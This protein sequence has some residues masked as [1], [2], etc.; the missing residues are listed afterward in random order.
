M[1]EETKGSSVIWGWDLWDSRKASMSENRRDL[2]RRRT[3]N[4]WMWRV[5]AG[6]AEAEPSL[7]AVKE[8]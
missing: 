3:V 6:E 7:A 2:A 4:S 5:D 8:A 1:R